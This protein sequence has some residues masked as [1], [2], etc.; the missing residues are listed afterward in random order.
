MQVRKWTK[1][2]EILKEIPVEDPHHPSSVLLLAQLYENLN[3]TGDALDI[4]NCAVDWFCPHEANLCS[5]FYSQLG[6]LMHS[7]GSFIPAADVSSLFLFPLS[8]WRKR[9]RF[10]LLIF[11]ILLSLSF[12]FPDSLPLLILDHTREDSMW[13]GTIKLRPEQKQ[14]PFH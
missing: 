3:K 10:S 6:N 2:E 14:F 9:K 11:H 4:L 13:G 8:S 1:A 12:S 7:Q 5:Q